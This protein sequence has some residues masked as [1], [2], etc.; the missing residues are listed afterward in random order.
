[1]GFSLIASCASEPIQN[2]DPETLYK[3]DMVLRVDGQAS[4]GA[5]V[6]PMKD[7]HTFHVQARGTLDLFTLTT[8]HRD[9]SKEKAW[10]IPPAIFRGQDTQYRD[11]E[12]KR[13]LDENQVRF[14]LRL[15]PVERSG[16]CL[17]EL[18]GY[19]KNGKHSWA[20]IDFL[21]AETTLPATVSCNGNQYRSG[22]VTI[23]QSR[24]EL[25]QLIQFDTEVE[26]SP[27]SEC[28]TMDKK[29]GMLFSFDMPRGR[30]VYAFREVKLPHRIHRLTTFGYESILIRE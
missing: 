25:V 6:V 30:C 9:W 3:R 7:V 5:I 11:P 16:G 19:D 15:T 22:G 10:K 23:C 28:D 29:R 14:Q 18:G 13:S 27:D 26:V 12:W 2:L 20:M 17:V 8:C 21:D 24:K 4:E 1:M